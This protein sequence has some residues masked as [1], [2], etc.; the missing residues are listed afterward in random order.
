MLCCFY[1]GECLL[2][3]LSFLPLFLSFLLSS[4]NCVIFVC[5]AILFE[6]RY[7]VLFPYGLYELCDDCWT[8]NF[9][10]RVAVSA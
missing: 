10:S 8:W 1:H 6:E 3:R 5:S 2:W 7:C 9:N 4:G